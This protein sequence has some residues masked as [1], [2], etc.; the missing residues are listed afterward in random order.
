MLGLYASPNLT[1]KELHI[2]PTQI[3]D[4]EGLRRLCFVERECCEEGE[5]LIVIYMIE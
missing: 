4:V 5:L 3:S 2:L 1:L